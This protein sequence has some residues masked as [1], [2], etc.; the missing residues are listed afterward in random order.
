MNKRQEVTRKDVERF[1]GCFLRGRFKILRQE[2]H[3]WSDALV[4]LIRE[5]CVIR[6]NLIVR[7]SLSGEFEETAVTEFY[8]QYNCNEEQDQNDSHL[9][10]M[11]EEE[12][13]NVLKA[14]LSRS[15]LVP[16][17]KRHIELTENLP[18]HL[19]KRRRNR[20]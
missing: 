8:E 2:R 15:S 9:D 6:H 16:S 10:T 13:G 18:H 14:L 7:M 5:G 1:F 12:G 11:L 3:G 20:K 17:R 4:I 19:W